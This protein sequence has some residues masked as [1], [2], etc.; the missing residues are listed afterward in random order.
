MKNIGER[1]AKVRE[2]NGLSRAEFGAKIGLSQNTIGRYERGEGVPDVDAA[3]LLCKIFGV[4]L[5]WLVNGEDLSEDEESK[6]DTSSVNPSQIVAILRQANDDLRREKNDLTEENKVLREEHNNLIKEN[7]ELSSEN[8]NLKMDLMRLQ[9]DAKTKE[10]EDTMENVLGS[11]GT[12]MRLDMEAHEDFADI[13]VL[14]LSGDL[15]RLLYIYYDSLTAKQKEK[16]QNKF[17]ALQSLTFRTARFR[18]LIKPV[19]N[20]KIMRLEGDLIETRCPKSY[21]HGNDPY[22]SNLSEGQVPYAAEDG[23]EYNK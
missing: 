9:Y 13:S 6:F 10:I 22:D 4:N 11:C 17:D 1:I 21:E 20:K 19:L 2:D 16:Y 14:I 5:S 7:K 3:N 15:R 18:T 12:V 23:D 8:A